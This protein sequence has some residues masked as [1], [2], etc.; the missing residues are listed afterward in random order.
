MIEI[1]F[2]KEKNR[3]VAL[4]GSKEVGVCEYI[5]KENSWSIAHTIVN[6]EYRGQNIAKRLVESVLEEAKLNNKKVTAT[7][8]Y[9]IK[10]MKLKNNN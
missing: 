6:P 9:A 2:E 1:K 4:D 3:S 5:E 10:L 7:C 8:S